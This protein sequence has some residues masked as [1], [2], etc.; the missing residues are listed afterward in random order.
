M[1][2]TLSLPRQDISFVRSRDGTRIAV[3]SMGHGPVIVRAAHW[4]GHVSQDVNSPVWRPWLE[5]LT[6]ANRLLRYDLRGC[7]L[8]DRSVS[9]IDFEAWYEDLEAVTAPLQQPFVL[10]GMSQG[11][12]LSITYALRHPE[13]VSKLVLIGGYGRGLLARGG[14]EP[15]RLEAE[16]LANLM[17]L[18]WGVEGSAFSRV[19]TRLFVP[20]GTADQV[21]WWREMERHA[22]SPHIAVRTLAILNEID[23][24]DAAAQLDLPVLVLHSRGDARIPFDEGRRLAAT[25]RGARLVTLDSSNHVLLA[26]EPAWDAMWQEIAGFLDDSKAHR[27]VESATVFADLSPAERE[28]LSSL[29]EGLGNAAIATRLGKSEKTVRNQVSIVLAKL[30]VNSRSEAIVR[31]L[32]MKEGQMP[33]H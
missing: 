28:V 24:M 1:N 12:A 18:G 14:G 17:R 15:A 13:R 7:G 10:L 23:V 20:G 11:A 33:R 29:A 22:A 32:S 27:P 26:Q 25:I 8:S 4:L 6:R 2:D 3:A 31:V 16:T 19:F 5:R 21:G 9:R 30:G